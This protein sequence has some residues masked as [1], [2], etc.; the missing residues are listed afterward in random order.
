MGQKQ[1]I[2]H[3]SKYLVYGT[4]TGNE[5]SED[6]IWRFRFFSLVKGSDAPNHT[7]GSFSTG[8]VGSSIVFEIYCGWFYV[9]TSQITTDPEGKDPVSYYGGCRYPLAD[10]AGPSPEYWRM[11][12][13]QQREGPIN[14]LW[15]DLSL[16]E[17]EN[18]GGLV[19]SE[20][21]REWQDGYSKQIR[22]F[23][24]EALNL[25]AVSDFNNLYGEFLESKQPEADSTNANPDDDED[26]V[27]ILLADCPAYSYPDS[28]RP[29]RR[30]SR[31]CHPEYYGKSLPDSR[32]FSLGSTKYRNYN[33][34]NSA[35]LDIVVDDIPPTECPQL[36]KHLR[37]RIGSRALTSPLDN[38]GLLYR[39][40]TTVDESLA[41]KEQFEDRGIYLWPPSD[42]P[43]EVFEL[44]NGGYDITKLKASSD[45]RTIIYMPGLSSSERNAPIVLINFDPAIRFSG[46]QRPRTG[47]FGT[48]DGSRWET[49]QTHSN[50]FQSGIPTGQGT[51]ANI[52]MP[53]GA[54]SSSNTGHDKLQSWVR[55]EPAAWLEKRHGI[56]FS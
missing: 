9:V 27:E 36:S 26:T 24:S 29:D 46:L 4:Y 2:R 7:I 25:T 51:S 54:S 52:G 5:D 47:K 10:R 1:F 8:D 40:D 23:Y 17:D 31:G 11:W 56:Q 14:D 48:S 45:E 21:R 12:R 55:I 39:P 30:C 16:Q 28:S 50:P 37:I 42:A 6:D 32:E 34:S 18:R 3:D 20:S 35:F 15:T 53:L 41:Y 13:R 43:A 33:H 19:I 49:Q 38:D 44:L 22:S